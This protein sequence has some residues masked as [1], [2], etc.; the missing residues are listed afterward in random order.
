MLNAC[1]RSPSTRSEWPRLKRIWNTVFV[2]STLACIV[3]AQETLA[4]SPLGPG[5]N[6]TLATATFISDPTKSWAVYAELHEGGEA[7]YYGFNVTEGDRIYVMLY[8][9]TRSEDQEFLPGF[10]LMGHDLVDQGEIPD[11]VEVP[12]EADVMVVE[13][14]QPAQ[15]TYEPFSPS[16]F[17]ELAQVDLTAPRSGTYYVAVFETNMG[18]HYGLAVGDREEYTLTEWILIPINLISVYQWAGHSLPIILLPLIVT[19]A[20]GL[21]LMFLRRKNGGIPRSA[22]AWVGTFAGLVFVGSGATILFQMALTL[23]VTPLG[24]EIVLTLVL[25]AIPILLGLGV[26]R[27]TL[28]AVKVDRRRRV[29]MAVLG[30]VAIFAWAGWLIGSALAIIASVLPTKSAS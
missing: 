21:I 18:G 16:G 5:D 23:T 15:A 25:A 4:H 29:Y 13:G 11:Y 28:D 14:E 3:L 7:Q 24:S 17:Y 22:F 8:K 26:L 2:L 1:T 30:I 10:V 12:A 19:V 27:L 20:V 6:E 9:S